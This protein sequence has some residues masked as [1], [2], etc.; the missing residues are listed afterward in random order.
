MFV[1]L[2]W[3]TYFH[4]LLN[5]LDIGVVPAEF[6]SIEGQVDSGQG[7]VHP[8]L[9]F[10]HLVEILEQTTLLFISKLKNQRIKSEQTGNC[11]I[12]RETWRH[13]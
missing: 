3:L 5:D 1:C 9:N 8:V 2:A 13:F 7:G 10:I 4:F 6:G 11:T 12:P